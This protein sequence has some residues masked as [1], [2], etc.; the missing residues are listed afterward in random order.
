MNNKEVVKGDYDVYTF[1][2]LSSNNLSLKLKK[3]VRGSKVIVDQSA[4]SFV[5]KSGLTPFL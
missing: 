4:Y 3:S 2:K 1:N 5:N